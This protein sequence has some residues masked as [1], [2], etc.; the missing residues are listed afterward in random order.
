MNLDAIPDSQRIPYENQCECGKNHTVLTQRGN[1]A[2]YD[3]EVYILCDCG[4][5]VEFILPVN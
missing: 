5:Y 1:F 4:E 2:E 3:T